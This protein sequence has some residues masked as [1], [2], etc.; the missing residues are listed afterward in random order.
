MAIPKNQLLT[1]SNQGAVATA[2]ITHK[3]ISAA[4]DD[5]KSPVRGKLDVYLQ[6]SYKN[7]TNIR[8]DSDVDIVGQLKDGTFY[9]D[10]SSLPKEQQ[11]AF[12]AYYSGKSMFSWDNFKAEVL[13]SLQ[14]YYDAS[15][16]TEGN[17]A[18]KVAAGSGR[19]ASDAVACVQFRKYRRFTSWSDCNYVEGIQFR[20][21]N[22]RRWIINFPK[23]HYKN[24]V[25]KNSEAK[26]NG[27]FK[28]TVR[29]FKNARCRLIDDETI[30]DD[31]A[32]SYF[33]ESLIYNVP[34]DKFENDI[35]VTFINII[36]YLTNANLANFMCMNKQLPLFGNTPEQWSVEKAKILVKSLNDLNTN[37]Q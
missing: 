8:G 16:V 27:L 9:Y 6:G 19:L 12:H 37:W 32:P 10:I 22:D 5:P 33:L 1:W 29:V 25:A 31:L 2:I 30:S 28:P 13:Q 14:N 4:L 15:A 34:D 7:D 26:T 24:G 21:T 35:Q 3:S 20:T 18:I 23:E 17:K 36:D 11:D